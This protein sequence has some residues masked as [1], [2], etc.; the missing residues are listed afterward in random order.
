MQLWDLPFSYVV[1]FNGTLLC[2]A[3]L[4]YVMICYAMLYYVRL[5][6]AM[7]LCC[8]VLSDLGY[9]GVCLLD[10]STVI[11]RSGD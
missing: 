3:M 6:N 1:W 9:D 11:P 10:V 2:Y 4:R 7:M 5:C 8:G